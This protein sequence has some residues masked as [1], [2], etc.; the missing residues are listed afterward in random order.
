MIKNLLSYLENENDLV[1]LNYGI[2]P[3]NTRSVKKALKQC[4]KFFSYE[5]INE[6]GAVEYEDKFENFSYYLVFGN[7]NKLYLVKNKEIF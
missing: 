7:D 1:R 2:I 3:L 4:G 6:A 5:Y